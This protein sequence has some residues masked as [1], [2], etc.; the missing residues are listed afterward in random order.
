MSGKSHISSRIRSASL[1]IAAA[2]VLQ[3]L[4]VMLFTPQGL[5]VLYPAVLRFFFRKGGF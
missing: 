5:S 1:F 3:F 4:C 2:A